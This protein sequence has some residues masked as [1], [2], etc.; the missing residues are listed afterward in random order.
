MSDTFKPV[1]EFNISFTA[2]KINVLVIVCSSPHFTTKKDTLYD[3]I[4]PLIWFKCILLKSQL[5]VFHF[6]NLF[7]KP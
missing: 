3:A 7:F 2:D 1:I 6:A 4:K 5:I